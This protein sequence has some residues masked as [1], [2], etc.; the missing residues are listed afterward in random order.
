MM[1]YYL[2]TARHRYT[3]NRYLASWGVKLIPRIRLLV[4]EDLN[5][6][7][8]LPLGTYI[9]SD[10]E[11]L[12]PQQTEMAAGAW[13]KLSSAGKGIRLLN[14]PTRSMR[15]YELLRTLYERGL[16]Q[17]NIYRLT[18]LRKP[19]KFPVFL[20]GENDHS[21]NQT[22]LLKSL[23]E[24]DDIIALFYDQRKS[25]D[26]KIITEFCD[27]SDEKGIFRKYAAF[28][29]GDQII[30][31][32]IFFGWH[33]MLKSHTNDVTNE[34]TLWE[35]QEY[36]ENNPHDAQL[37]EIFRLANVQYGRIDYSMLNSVTQVWEI[38]TNPNVLSISS[39]ERMERV[40]GLPISEFFSKQFELAFEAIDCKPDS[41]TWIAIWTTPKIPFNQKTL[42]RRTN[43]VLLLL[44]YVLSL[45][46]PR[47]QLLIFKKFKAFRKSLK[48][49]K[50]SS[51]KTFVDKD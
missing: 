3:I 31:R 21:G 39:P 34:E 45:M 4:Y 7:R 40:S 19:E 28:I 29:I 12:T 27:T 17:F 18:E 10:I 41:T 49:F 46:P 26:D 8:S 13:E 20:R 50:N 16:N 2:V 36:I 37:R 23:N 32:G 35:E 30:P 33:W 14:H 6:L 22:P 44:D 11:R 38:N 43:K 24:L 51:K 15:R 5:K 48:A 1:I 47:T 25:L 42:E 9:F